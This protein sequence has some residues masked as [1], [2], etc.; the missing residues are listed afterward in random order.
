LTFGLYKV[1]SLEH[2]G[3]LTFLRQYVGQQP[4]ILPGSVVII[5]NPSNELLLQKRYEGGWGLPKLD[6]SFEDTASARRN[7]TSHHR[8]TV[9][10]CFF[11]HSTIHLERKQAVLSLNVM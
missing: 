10:R 7:R 1:N 8:F 11:W 2:D 5:L 4:I 9:T 3:I 6:E